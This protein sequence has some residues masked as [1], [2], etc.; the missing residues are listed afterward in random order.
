MKNALEVIC[1][2][3]LMD[4]TITEKREVV[5]IVDE[6]NGEIG[7]FTR[8]TAAKKEYKIIYDL[9]LAGIQASKTETSEQGLQ[10]VVEEMNK[11]AANG[12][13]SEIGKLAINST[14][15]LKNA[16]DIVNIIEQHSTI[17]TEE[18]RNVENSIG[19]ITAAL[20]SLC[21]ITRQVNVLS[22]ELKSI[23]SKLYG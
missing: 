22:G 17:I 5:M 14:L 6:N 18:L 2:V 1:K 10:N 13:F 7:A 21:T 20:A 8:T 16:G 19:R 3:S 4:K 23:A 11:L 9:F 15:P 12:T